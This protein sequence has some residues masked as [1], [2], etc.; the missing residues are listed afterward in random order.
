MKKIFIWGFALLGSVWTLRAG[1]TLEAELRDAEGEKL[2]VRSQTVEVRLYAQPKGGEALWGETISVLLNESG[3]FTCQ[4]ADGVGSK[5]VA[6]ESLTQVLTTLTAQ[7]AYLGFTVVGSGEMKPRLSLAAV[8]RA[9]VAENAI[10]APRGFSV[11]NGTLQA[12]GFSSASGTNAHLTVAG[13]WVVA[14]NLQ[15]EG[16]VSVRGEVKCLSDGEQRDDL[17]VARALTVTGGIEGPG[18]VPVGGLIL[19]SG[20]SDAIPDGWALCDGKSGRPDLKDT[21]VLG[22]APGEVLQSGGENEHALAVVEIPAHSHTA[23]YTTAKKKDQDLFWVKRSGGSTD[24]TWVNGQESL[25]RNTDEAGLQTPHENRPPFY[26]LCY[27]I[28]VR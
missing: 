23:N 15:V 10:A 4:L 9:L 22:S 2:A 16:G 13:D 28:R 3:A 12:A 18:T 5:L 11:T 20:S 24:N 1:I 14:G 27:L 19:W 8:P 6:G 17:V 26:R 7:G 21:F 25:A